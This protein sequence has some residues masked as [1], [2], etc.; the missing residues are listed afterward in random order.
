MAFSGD[1]H[2]IPYSIPTS[3]ITVMTRLSFTRELICM[4]VV[5]VVRSVTCRVQVLRANEWLWSGHPSSAIL[6]V[7]GVRSRTEWKHH[8]VSD[9]AVP[10]VLSVLG[11]G[12]LFHTR[13][14]TVTISSAPSFREQTDT[15]SH[16][17]TSQS[18]CSCDTSA[19]CTCRSSRR[20]VASSFSASYQLKSW[21]SPFLSL[22]LCMCLLNVC[23]P[24]AFVSIFV[25]SLFHS[26][27]EA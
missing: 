8:A 6:Q 12:C 5:C 27:M 9:C 2:S 14:S 24:S 11:L 21:L 26:L 3:W 4:E 19:S 18:P 7:E 17:C 25:G 20:V 16:T 23:Y 22:L 1:P 13:N 15:L 10:K